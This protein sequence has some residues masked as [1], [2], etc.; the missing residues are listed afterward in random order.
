M[1]AESLVSLGIMSELDAEL[2]RRIAKD[3]LDRFEGYGVFVYLKTDENT[4]LKRIQ[5]RGREMEK[6][7]IDA[8]YLKSLNKL[9]DALFEALK[10]KEELIVIDTTELS[11]RDTLDMVMKQLKRRGSYSMM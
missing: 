11:E 1:F 5:Q 2:Y 7:S 8:E 6:S 10:E 9:F 3:Y 4:L